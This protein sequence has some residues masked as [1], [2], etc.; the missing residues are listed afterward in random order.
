MNLALFDFD[1]TITVEGTWR[2]FMRFGVRRARLFAGNVLLAPVIV[3]YRLG[4]VSASRGRQMA[5]R[6]GFQ[7]ED[8]ATVRKLGSEFATTVING[9]LRPHAIER[10]D[11]HRSQGDDVVIVS[12]SLDVY[13]GPWCQHRSLEYI[14]TTLEERD[15][16]LTGRYLHGDCC[17]AEKVRR[18]CQRYELSRYDVVYACGDSGEDREMLGLASRKYYRWREISE[19]GP[20][21]F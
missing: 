16:K 14:C 7:G 15:G 20:S 12:A 18:V 9:M 21:P 6:L 10:I 13:L 3:G 4:A 11:W 1:G 8:A 5:V 19:L 17:G 2:P